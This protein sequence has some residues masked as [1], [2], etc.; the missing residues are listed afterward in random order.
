LTPDIVAGP[1]LFGPGDFNGDGIL[2]LAV[3]DTMYGTQGMLLGKGDGTFTPSFTSGGGAPRS[4]VVGD[5]NGDGKADLA[6]AY[7]LSHEI[8][9]QL[10]KGDGT[11]LSASTLDTTVSPVFITTGDFNGDGVADLAVIV[12]DYFNHGNV[13]VA[14]GNGDGTFQ[15]LFG[16]ELSTGGNPTSIAVGDFNADGMADLAVTD[17]SVKIL[18][19]KG[20]GTFTTAVS[21]AAGASPSSVIAADLN[22]DGKLDL[23]VANSGDSTVTVLLGKGDGTFTPA[24]SPATGSNPSSITAGDFDGDGKVDLAVS[25]SGDNSVTVLLGNGDGTFRPSTQSA[26]GKSMQFIA[27]RDFNGDGLTDLIVSDDVVADNPVRLARLTQTSTA[28]AN[29]ISPTAAGTHQV[30]ASYPG[31]AHYGSSTSN[32]VTL[33]GSAPSLSV[34]PASNS[35]TISQAGGTGSNSIQISSIQ[36]FSGTVSLSCAV[37]FSD[38]RTASDM[39]TCSLNPRQGN[40]TSTAPLSTTLTAS[41]TAKSSLFKAKGLWPHVGGVLAAMLFL[42]FLARPRLRQ[43]PLLVVV[44]M[45]MLSAITACSSGS[46]GGNKTPANP[47]TTMGNYKM[48]I[49]ATGPASP[50]STIISLSVQ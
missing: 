39:P 4:V 33:T 27:A 2:D 47:G 46:S 30:T 15:P 17:G 16:E 22:G 31:D 32:T 9:I 1:L 26:I 34:V 23:A 25:N 7:S 45:F 20:D 36:G 37:T 13:L 48:V 14:L 11:F 3:R 10:G 50:V 29:G 8:T 21:T 12:F 5:F 38:S 43:L 35:L 28:T 18:L 6:V 24:T 49:T 44:A 40:V 41:T 42:G 19:G